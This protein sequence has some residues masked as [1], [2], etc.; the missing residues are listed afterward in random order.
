M[1]ERKLLWLC[2]PFIVF[3]LFMN[4]WGSG[5][6]PDLSVYWPEKEPLVVEGQIYKAGHSA[7]AST[8]YLKNI[9][10]ISEADKILSA[11]T[12]EFL[13]N[14][15]ILVYMKD[16]T[17][18]SIGD[19]V[20]VSGKCLY[21]HP[22]SNPGCFDGQSYYGAQHIY[23]MLR[24]GIIEKKMSHTSFF[25]NLI[26]SLQNRLNYVIDSSAS[27]VDGTVLK[28][29][30]LGDRSGLDP[31]LKELYQDNGI[32]HVLAISGLHIS[33]I[34]MSL[35]SFLRK[36]GISFIGCSVI[37][38]GIILFY[39]FLTGFPT[40]AIRAIL[41]FL[42][43]LGSQILGRTYDLTNS[44]VLAAVIM[45]Y[46]NPALITQSGFL[47]SFGAV[48][49]VLSTHLFSSK[50]LKR[51]SFGIS[52]GT[53]LMTLPLTAY[54]FFQVPLTGIF[55]NL[56]VVPSMTIIIVLGL[57]GT[58]VS[59]ISSF[60]GSFV[61]GPVHY[62][63]KITLWICDM[64]RRIPCSI[65]I[66]GR[67]EM[68]QIILY[69][70]ILYGGMWIYDLICDY[71][72]RKHEY[73]LVRYESLKGSDIRRIFLA[74]IAIVVLFFPL[75]KGF[76]ITFLNVG[77]G[78]GTCIRNDN[79]NVYMVDGGS[80]SESKLGSY[81]LEP[82]LKCMGYR[83]V[84]GWFVSHY[85]SDHVNGLIE[86]LENYNRDFIG[87]NI[88]GITIKRIVLPDLDVEEELQKEILQLA[89]K[90]EIPVSYLRQGDTIS[91]AQTCFTIYNPRKGVTYE[92][93]NAGSMV[94]KVSYKDLSV[95]MTGDVQGNGEKGLLDIDMGKIDIL[96]VA[97]HGSKNSSG[98]EILEHIKPSMAV[99]SVG[100]G[101]R[102][103]HPNDSV[104]ENLEKIGCKVKR[105]DQDGPIVIK[106]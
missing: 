89:K 83:K 51:S 91:D 23:L 6:V 18:F 95:L 5:K 4:I 92:D 81:T 45:L 93:S 71:K 77:Q 2:I 106:R 39:G 94:M 8:I 61:F 79:G 76:S 35:Y 49:G 87:N 65:L 1:K 69:Y 70:L 27:D 53:W 33:M 80:S 72:I 38:F 37:S 86:M 42:I 16:D 31:Q 85:D 103:G 10:V 74:L 44:L 47:L 59:F 21:P 63:L 55:L 25:G 97:H 64:V 19:Y 32:I 34:G 13:Y 75:Q 78:D 52:V 82:Y 66:T 43:Y 22:P 60:L 36:R 48:L 50:L 3:I 29:I 11:D 17:D 40:S 26:F 98:V 46:G 24:S 57:L 84:D 9:S 105:T 41:M 56:F 102:Y 96:K 15:N 12:K 73:G 68:L 14:S 7:S 90:N 30:L 58:A 28:S 100:K 54:S 104:L 101:N 20:R 88:A 62:I 99:I 67:P